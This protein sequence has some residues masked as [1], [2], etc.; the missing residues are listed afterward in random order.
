MF[1]II[2]IKDEQTFMEPFAADSC[3]GSFL[4]IVKLELNIKSLSGL[5][6]DQFMTGTLLVDLFP[7]KL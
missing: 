4:E 5:Q 1:E 7:Y 2:P 3:V 6:E